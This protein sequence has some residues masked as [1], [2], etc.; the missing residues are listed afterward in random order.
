MILIFLWFSIIIFLKKR[1]NRENS[2][3]VNDRNSFGVLKNDK[4]LRHSQFERNID[5]EGLNALD[6][7]GSGGE[8]WNQSIDLLENPL[9]ESSKESRK[10]MPS[11]VWPS[12][13]SANLFGSQ[14]Q[15]QKPTSSVRHDRSQN[16]D[17]WSNII[18]NNVNVNV[19]FPTPS[20][21]RLSPLMLPKKSSLDI[22]PS[23][24]KTSIDDRDQHHHHRNQQNRNKKTKPLYV[25]PND[26]DDFDS[27]SKKR[28]SLSAL[29]NSL[30]RQKAIENLNNENR[31]NNSSEIDDNI[32]QVGFLWFLLLCFFWFLWFSNVFFCF[33]FRL[34]PGGNI[35][36]FVPSGNICS[37]PSG[38]FYHF[39]FSPLIPCGNF[40]Y[41]FRV[42]F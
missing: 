22:R 21:S 4:K 38:N 36:N 24:K 11:I 19:F 39:P 12:T 5:N 25:C 13:S 26:F 40:S 42:R 17:I 15:S 33:S 3:S 32:I 9:F 10:P 2:D 20:T 28:L 31:Q 37:S 30:C 27:I 29:R 14:K 18:G 1:Q 8:L 35:W 16:E 6:D 23:P 34:V 41:F 7:F